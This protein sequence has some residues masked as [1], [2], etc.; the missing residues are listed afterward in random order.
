MNEE[1]L[2]SGHFYHI[3]NCGINGENLFRATE[4][5]HSFLSLMDKYVLPVADLFAWVLMPN[6]FHL[7]VRIKENVRYKYSI[8]DR[9]HQGETWFDDH[10]W[11][12]I[13]LPACAAPGSVKQPVN[14]PINVK[15]PKPHLHFS[16]LFNAYAKYYNQRYTRHGGLFER[17]FNRKH[18]DNERYFKR[19]VLYIHNN[20]VHH[21]FCSH[22]IEYPWT[23]YLTCISIKPTKLHREKV[24]GWFDSQAEFKLLHNEKMEVEKIDKWLEI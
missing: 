10:K 15:I 13:D 4:N 22:P 11:E 3:Y 14:L 23:S 5:Y 18:I 7:L 9:D 19:M 20:P 2:I 17:R 21:G 16:H 6:H 1:E 12:T 24:M 8:T